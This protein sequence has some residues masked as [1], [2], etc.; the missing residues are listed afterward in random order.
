ML[1]VGGITVAVCFTFIN[2]EIIKR[3]QELLEQRY[4][5]VGITLKWR[6]PVSVGAK[7]KP[8]AKALSPNDH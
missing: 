3:K 4:F 7:P 5:Q 1:C 2:I 8:F 6:I